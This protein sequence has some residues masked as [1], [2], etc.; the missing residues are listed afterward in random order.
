MK[1]STMQINRAI[2]DDTDFLTQS[3][4]NVSRQI[5]LCAGN[6]IEYSNEKPI[7]LIS[8]PSGSSKTTAA[9]KLADFLRANGKGVCC[10]SMDKYFKS[11]TDDEKELKRLNKIDLE[12]PERVDK[13]YLYNDIDTLLNGGDIYLPSYSFLT[14]SRTLTDKKIN[15][16][17]GFIIIEGIHALNSLLMADCDGISSKIYVSVRTRVTDCSGDTL[18]PC[19][20]RLLRRMMRDKLFRGRSA[21]ETVKAFA[22]V[23]YGENKYIMPYKRNADFNIDTFIGYEPCVYKKYLYKKLVALSEKYA[24]VRDIVGALDEV[25]ELDIER[26]PKDAFIREFIGG[27]SLS[28]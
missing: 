16:E 19:K 21:E 26:I 7:I 5:A 18:H 14:N 11:F 6:I 17:N 22:G 28:Y 8:G 12:S 25:A 2:K 10:L 13:E 9:I 23:Q 20:I 4:N 15:R 24:D 1:I 3:E 27:S